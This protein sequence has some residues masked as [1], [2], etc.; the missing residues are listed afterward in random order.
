MCFCL[1]FKEG[2]YIFLSFWLANRKKRVCCEDLFKNLGRDGVKQ[3]SSSSTDQ[4]RALVVYDTVVKAM[5]IDRLI[6]WSFICDLEL[7]HATHFAAEST[8]LKFEYGG[9]FLSSIFF[10]FFEVRSLDVLSLSC[11][12][13]CHWNSSDTV[14]KLVFFHRI[15]HCLLLHSQIKST[16]SVVSIFYSLIV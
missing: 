8:P 16:D 2:L 10:Q 1:K 13:G 11:L 5:H 3:R 9:H 7:F 6:E 15:E 12:Q 4:L 14:R